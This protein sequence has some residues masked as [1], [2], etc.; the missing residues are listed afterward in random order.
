[1]GRDD[2]PSDGTLRTLD[3]ALTQTP[4][5]PVLRMDRADDVVRAGALLARAGLSALEVTA[6][7][8]DWPHAIGRLRTECPDMV[9]GLGTVRDPDTARRA[10]GTGAQFLVTPYPV[11]GLR[12]AVPDVP[13]IGGGWTPAEVAASADHGLAKLFPAHV[14][15]PAY[16]GSLLAVLPGARLV[17]TGGIT[18]AEIGSWLDAGAAAVGVGSDLV[19]AV[20]SDPAQVDEMLAAITGGR[21]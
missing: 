21:S 6:T 4:V 2:G 9:V 16:L 14:G 13:V 12:E 20:E 10:V 3:R 11:P 17:P 1:M 15:G 8:A 19:R 7:T 5:L 18:L